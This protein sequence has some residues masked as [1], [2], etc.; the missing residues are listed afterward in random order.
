MSTNNN[1]LPVRT[2]VKQY[3]DILGSV[4]NAKKAFTY[5]LSPI[6]TLDG[7]T[8]NSTAFTVKTN[9]TPVVI[10]NYNKGATVGMGSG[11]SNS[12]RFGPCT[13]IIYGNTDVPYSYDLSIHEGIDRATVNED[14]EQSIAD[15]IELQAISQTKTMNVK[16]GEYIS[17]SA[18]HTFTLASYSQEDVTELF[19]DLY[20]YYVDNEVDAGLTAYVVP[21]IYNTIVDNGLATTAKNSTVDIDN[22]IVYMFKG[23]KIEATPTK[24]FVE[25]DYAYVSAD[26]IV[27]PFVG[28][29]TARTIETEDFDGVKLQ[30]RA[31]GGTFATD[32][33]KVAIVKVTAAEVTP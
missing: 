26:G 1:N 33:N 20:K 24:Y 4:F 22:N 15:R 32:D 11:T 12:S 18:S 8:E 5:A 3:T 7:V 25:G 16:N 28:A 9:N 31:K 14:F 19:N 27:I 17:G 13:E 23:F 29:S 21:E 6:Q 10:N 2:Y 30:A